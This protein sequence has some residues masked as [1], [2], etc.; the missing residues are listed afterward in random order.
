MLLLLQLLFILFAMAAVTNRFHTWICYHGLSLIW[1]SQTVIFKFTTILS[2]ICM[3]LNSLLCI[4]TQPYHIRLC[5]QSRRHIAIYQLAIE[6]YN[7]VKT[8]FCL[9]KYTYQADGM[10]MIEV[11]TV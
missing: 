5:E 10:I 11:L 1:F 2:H 9:T 4:Y 6:S 8:K 7:Y 3:Y